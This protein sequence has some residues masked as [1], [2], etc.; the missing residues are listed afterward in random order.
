[1]K[2]V[3]DATG[4]INRTYTKHEWLKDRLSKSMPSTCA[5]NNN[6]GNNSNDNNE[7]LD[8]DEDLE[9]YLEVA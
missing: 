6:T 3:I 9:E 1:M 2:S 4:T 7:S 5:I 8:E